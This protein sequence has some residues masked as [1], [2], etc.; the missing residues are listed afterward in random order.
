MNV[1]PKNYDWIE[2]YDKVIDLTEYTFSPRS[3]YRRYKAIKNP[4]ARW[5]NV[6]RAVSSE[7]YGRIRFFKKVREQLKE[8]SSFRSYFEGESTELPDFYIQKV[9]KD[10]GIWWEWLPKG[11]LHHD[12]NAYLHK[13][14][15]KKAGA[16]VPSL[17]S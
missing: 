6:M 2:F 5:M 8:D 1:K 10:L 16:T 3:I 4:T 9:K 7:G 17:L 12:Q 15:G 13:Q 11:A 14:A